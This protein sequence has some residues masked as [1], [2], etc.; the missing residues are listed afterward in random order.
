M[1]VFPPYCSTQASFYLQA[2]R[3]PSYSPL[4]EPKEIPQTQAPPQSTGRFPSTSFHP[5]SKL[6]KPWNPSGPRTKKPSGGLPCRRLG[7]H[8]GVLLLLLTVQDL[9]YSCSPLWASAT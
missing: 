8:R 7:S 3:V 2:H 9:G 6:G 4:P 5:P 1:L